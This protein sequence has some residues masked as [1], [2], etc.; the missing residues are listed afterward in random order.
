MT[1]NMGHKKE[2]RGVWFDCFLFSFLLEIENGDGNAF[3]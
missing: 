3:G 1:L 2:L